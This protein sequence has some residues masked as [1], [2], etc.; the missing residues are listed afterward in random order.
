VKE[1]LE[2]LR[3]DA[4]VY[5]ALGAMSV[6]ELRHELG[7]DPIPG[8]DTFRNPAQEAKDANEAKAAQAKDNM[9]NKVGEDDE[10]PSKSGKAIETPHECSC[11]KKAESKPACACQHGGKHMAEH[12]DGK[13]DDKLRPKPPIK[14][15]DFNEP[16]PSLQ[17]VMEDAVR[18][19]LQNVAVGVVVPATPAEVTAATL[20]QFTPQLAAAVSVPVQ[21]IFKNGAVVGAEQAGV[22]A[23]FGLRQFSEDAAEYARTND[24]RLAGS[25]TD[26]QVER[27]KEIM[28]RGIERGA[29]QVEMA[30]E[31]RE[32]LVGEAPARAG[33]I[34]RDQSARAHNYGKLESWKKHGVWGSMIQLAPGACPACVAFVEAF[35]YQRPLG[36]AY[37]ELGTTYAVPGKEK[38]VEVDYEAIYA[39]PFHVMCRC[40]VQPVMTKPLGWDE[41]T[42]GE[43]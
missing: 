1:D 35:G 5:V 2:A 39:P 19:W 25:V 42:Q 31:V 41:K 14:L 27:I 7:R 3:E 10:P 22:S 15:P 17:A 34:A 33:I 24:L 43:N 9:Q 8:G 32:V 18:K 40:Y 29:S 30:K 37:A 28:G 21:D 16:P 11:H 12:V 20:G 6:N 23:S 13:D 4:K 26:T 38:M 36:E